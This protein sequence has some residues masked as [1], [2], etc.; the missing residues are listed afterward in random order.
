MCA[1]TMLSKL[2]KIGDTLQ[3]YVSI[4]SS[5]GMPVKFVVF[6]GALGDQSS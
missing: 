1:K 4:I 3:W 6:E 5:L 2:L